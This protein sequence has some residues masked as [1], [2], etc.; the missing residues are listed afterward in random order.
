MGTSLASIITCFWNLE[1][2]K[3]A[4]ARS[5]SWAY[6]KGL[7]SESKKLEDLLFR[8][9]NSLNRHHELRQSSHLPSFETIESRGIK[10]LHWLIGTI[11]PI[12]GASMLKT[13][14]EDRF[15]TTRRNIKTELDKNCEA[16][17]ISF[18]AWGANNHIHILIAIVHW[19][20]P[21]F[22]RCSIGIE[23]AEMVRGKSG[24]VM[25]DIIWESFGP[26]YQAIY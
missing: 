12:K 14:I 9:R 10:N 2:R 24:E 15:N 17:S 8:I 20:A 26:D 21:H 4:L 3:K 18:D 13:R 1:W 22:Q 19:L 6:F 25:A 7:T 11:C 23:F 5:S 16:F